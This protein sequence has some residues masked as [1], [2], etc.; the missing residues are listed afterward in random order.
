MQLLLIRHCAAAGQAAEAPLS[1]T[2][3]NDALRLADN[4]ATS[5][6][7]AL[8][9]SPFTRAVTTLQPL[10]DRLGLAIIRDDRLQERRLS[11]FDRADWLEHLQQSF[12]DPAYRLEGGESLAEAQSRGLAALA[13]IASAGHNRPAVASHGNLIAAVLC[14]IDPAFGFAGWRSMTNPDIFRLTLAGP[15]PVA[16]ERISGP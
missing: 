13:D 1:E 16:F 10:A 15:K 7:D 11:T 4:L 12:A 9:S 5:G 2:G 14:A 6:I 3:V 8:Y